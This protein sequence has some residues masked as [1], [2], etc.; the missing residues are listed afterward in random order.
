MQIDPH[1]LVKLFLELA[2]IDAVSR[3]ERPVADYIIHYLS[4]LNMPV[5]EDDTGPKIQ[6]NCGNLITR[7][8]PDQSGSSP[9]LLM[10]HLDTVSSTAQLKPV[11]EQ[12]IIHSDGTTILGGDN[13]AGV[14]LILYI[15]TELATRN[16][17]H[18]NLEIVFSVAEEVGM[19]GA[20]HLD[21]S[22]IHSREGYVLDCSHK[23]GGYVAVT[24]TAIDF[25]VDFIGRAAHSG[26]NPD[27]GIN[28]LSMAIEV[29]ANFPVGQLDSQT[30]SNIGIINGGTAIN[31][32]PERVSIVGEIRSF[33]QEKINSLRHQFEADFTGATQ[34]YGGRIESNFATGFQGFK[35]NHQTAVK[36]LEAAF[37]QLGL[38]PTPL[39]Y[40][41]GSDANVLNSRGIT[42]VNLGIGVKN[43]HSYQE[44]IA[45]QD[46][47]D[48]AQ[49]L[50]LLLEVKDA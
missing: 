18:R 20:S 32:V 31:I 48:V 41:G 10:A 50:L 43:P 8:F 35:L 2:Q 24:P 37:I 4:Q 12:G 22:R 1:K 38:T 42:A 40:F 3:Q 23:P 44:Q 21:F 46:L 28:A 33:N 7:R 49:L 36:R 30:V 11:I 9:V 13:R 45:I 5:E 34:K 29:L 27:N 19:Y 26:V 39:T 16:L 14:A 47:V 25:K 15:L 6:G 17:S